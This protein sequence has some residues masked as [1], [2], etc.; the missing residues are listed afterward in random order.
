MSLLHSSVS[1][2][3]CGFVF[4]QLIHAMTCQCWYEDEGVCAAGP[5]DG[6]ACCFTDG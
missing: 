3:V 4:C 6:V 1:R 5:V 2:R